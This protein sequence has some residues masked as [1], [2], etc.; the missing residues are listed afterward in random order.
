MEAAAGPAHPGDPRETAGDA[1]SG[2]RDTSEDSDE[3]PL[4]CLDAEDPTLLAS[5]PAYLP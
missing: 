3:R 2:A 5:C 4:R 1:P